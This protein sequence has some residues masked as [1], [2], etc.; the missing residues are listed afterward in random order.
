MTE[1]RARQS[2]QPPK[3][4]SWE[5]SSDGA[6]EPRAT[7]QPA[8]E[9]SEANHA[10]PAAD[11]VKEGRAGEGLSRGS[12]VGSKYR[13]GG[14]LLQNAAAGSGSG[15]DGSGHRRKQSRSL[16]QSIRSKPKGS[17]KK[18]KRRS[19]GAQEG[20]GIAQPDAARRSPAP[21]ER[22]PS[23]SK[24]EE[25][26][27]AQEDQVERP[28]LDVE[29]AQIVDMALRISLSRRAASQRVVSQ[30]T[31]P[32]LAPLPDSAGVSSLRH[33]LLQQRKVS[34]TDSPRPDRP[35]NASTMRH[36]LDSF[37]VTATDGGYRYHISRSTLARVQRAKEYIELMAQYRRLLASLPPLRPTDEQQP[38]IASSAKGS[39]ASQSSI[40]LG[41]QYNPLQYIRNRKVRARERQPLDGEAQGFKDVMQVTKWVDAV[42]EWS[43]GEGHTRDEARSLPAFA[44]AERQRNVVPSASEGSKA[45]AKLARRRIDWLIEPADLIADT[46]WLEQGNNKSLIQDRHWNPLY[47][48]ASNASLWPSPQIEERQSGQSRP[49]TKDQN[50]E[51]KGPKTRVDEEQSQTS[52]RP[53]LL[54]VRGIHHRNS[55]SGHNHDFL[56]LRRGSG[57]DASD[58]DGELREKA[59][60]GTMTTSG[61]DI[62]EKQMMEMIAKEERENAL[63]SSRSDISPPQPTSDKAE[64][65]SNLPSHMHSRNGSLADISEAD[66]KGQ[67][68]QI[69]PNRLG[70]D[71]PGQGRR[72]L[73]A[74]TAPTSPD[75]PSSRDSYARFSPT[76][77]R[78]ASPPRNPFTKV[79]YYFGDRKDKSAYIDDRIREIDVDADLH[80]WSIGPPPAGQQTGQHERKTSSERRLSGSP[81]RKP[82]HRSSMEGRGHLRVPSTKVREEPA[83]ARGI[84][85]APARIDNAFR[86]GVSKIGDIIWRKGA[87]GDNAVVSEGL[88]T[89][90]SEEQS[91]RGRAGSRAEEPPHLR[92]SYL[93]QMPASTSDR[94][95]CKHPHEPPSETKS[96][97]RQ[98][99]QSGFSDVRRQVSA[100]DVQS[101]VPES[102]PER[103]R[104]AKETKEDWGQRPVLPPSLGT[105]YLSYSQRTNTSH[106]EKE[107][108][109]ISRREIAR[110]RALLLSS[111]VMA[112]E[113]S[114]R[115]NTP[116]AISTTSRSSGRDAPVPWSEIA[117]LAA[118]QALP[119][120]VSP[121][122]SY[123]LA[124][125]VLENSIATSSHQWQEKAE[126]FTSETAPALHSRLDGLRIKLA[127]DLSST[128]R[129][130][131]DEADET[132]R[133]VTQTQ[134]LRV[135]R[136]V[137]VI[138]K[139]LRRRRRRFRWVRRG[140]WL[141]LEWV[142][143]GFMWYVWFVVM[144]LRVVAGVGRGA[145]KAV[146]WLF[147]L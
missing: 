107:H 66:D 58:S 122:E 116:Q 15:E 110:L 29:S 44:V 11:T 9:S 61:K 50:E 63:R 26:P 120:S 10:P 20:L 43:N 135:K 17:S 76:P 57:S 86:T 113:V 106:S 12:L 5:A 6:T 112:L 101:P 34:R 56:R 41:R 35:R 31:P 78:G 22:E 40:A 123:P 39:S 99:V 72:S 33:H 54:S 74:D 94:Q 60:T 55:S 62:L 124:A 42:L 142:L 79:K 53:R 7:R 23:S 70:V 2:P 1:S 96:S 37:D 98:S 36:A 21:T 134:R 73:D 127:V 115:A 19:E 77:S 136:V 85:K 28:P 82:S 114:R 24:S 128:I 108:L 91:G 139:M 89:D 97:R 118:K 68:A 64:A 71:V 69:I 143:V 51:S 25:T 111:G 88:M 117:P 126:A 138:E 80:R 90:D 109:P 46:Y 140:M 48:R 65:Q 103:D 4:F 81:T 93:D 119:E 95:I 27:A 84:F 141:G 47:P 83:G 30:H 67:Q 8:T 125:R 137:D 18:D 130:A 87:E 16:L 45:A 145:V 3:R 132:S 32:R 38:H 121:L 52:S 100:P 14:F 129:G 49:V 105:R 75:Q 144:V 146:R 13:S 133:E 147:W 131:S 102:E 92:K 104:E 59:R